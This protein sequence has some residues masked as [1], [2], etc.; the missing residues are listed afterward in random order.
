MADE[1][2][3]CTCTVTNGDA[4]VTCSG[5]SFLTTLDVNDVFKKNADGEPTYHVA[6][7]TDDTTFELT[8]AY[9]GS[10][11]TV[12]CV[13]QRSFTTNLHLAR[14][15]SGD[16][17]VA[18]ILTDEVIDVLDD[19]CVNPTNNITQADGK[20]IA[21]D[22]IRA[23]DGDGLKLTDDG[24]NGIFVKD[25]GNVG[26]GTTSPGAKLEVAQSA[27]NSGIKI[28]GYDTSSD[29][30]GYLYVDN[31]DVFFV[32]GTAG[33]NM[34]VGQNAGQLYLRTAGAV[35]IDQNNIIVYDDKMAQFGTDVDYSIGYNSADDTLRIADGSDLTT[36]PRVTL[37]SNGN[38]GIGTT[39]FGTSAAKVLGIG[40]GTAPTSSP[41]DMVQLYAEDVG[42]SS[43]LK[44]R[45]EAGNVTTLSANVEVYPD[46]IQPSDKYPYVSYKENVFAGVGVYIAQNKLAELVQEWAWENGKLPKDKK[47]IEYVSLDSSRVEDWDKNEDL[48]AKQKYKKELNDYIQKTQIEVSK[49]EAV[50]NDS[51]K[52]GCFEENGKYYR[53]PTKEE[54]KE[55]VVN[56]YKKKPKPKWLKIKHKKS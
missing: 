7:V 27:H 17:G 19:E 29:T 25:G 31:N 47:I 33:K 44:V 1:Q 34:V 37:K 24:G 42:G 52:T 54:A 15:A 3:I 45:D 13:I 35:R 9:A 2:I 55:K 16:Q 51:L 11:E 26:I 36:T 12:E 6:S 39:T 23:R 43:E 5:Q 28:T 20:Y 8:S 22:Q 30:S 46:D 53:R 49:S 50:E 38:V 41:A 10:T 14:P 4:T 48:K 56:P 18:E 32:D 40:N 21:T